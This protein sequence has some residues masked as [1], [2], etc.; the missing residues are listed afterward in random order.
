MRQRQNKKIAANDTNPYI[1]EQLDK[2]LE[3]LE[4]YC[5]TQASIT[6]RTYDEPLHLSA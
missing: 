5:N 4:T 6:I 2:F 3:L 1:Q